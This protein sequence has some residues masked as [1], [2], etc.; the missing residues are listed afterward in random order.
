MCGKQV[1]VKDNLLKN[2]IRQINNNVSQSICFS[3]LISLF[4]RH[5][6]ENNT[7]TGDAN[8]FTETMLQL[9]N[10]RKP[11]TFNRFNIQW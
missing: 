7:N 9:Q 8:G 5:H 3:K 2:G 1:I 6:K 11:D 10:R 4:S